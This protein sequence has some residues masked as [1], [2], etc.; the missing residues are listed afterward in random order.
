[1]LSHCVRVVIAYSA[2]VGELQLVMCG[3]HRMG[4]VAV[5]VDVLCGPRCV[6]WSWAG[7]ADTGRVAVLVDHRGSALA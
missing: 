6:A 2:T 5:G 1:M 7:G 4:I 3:W